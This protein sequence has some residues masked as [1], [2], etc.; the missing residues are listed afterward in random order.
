[1][2]ANASVY[3][4]MICFVAHYSMIRR[5]NVYSVS[6]DVLEYTALM[7]PNIEGNGPN[8]CTSAVLLPF[9]LTIAT[10]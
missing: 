1:M 4:P 3:A 5:V 7:S 10:S 6:A 8:S 2:C 9:L